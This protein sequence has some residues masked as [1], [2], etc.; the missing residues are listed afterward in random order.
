MKRQAFYSLCSTALILSLLAMLILVVSVQAEG[1]EYIRAG[2]SFGSDTLVA[3]NLQN[4][5]GSGYEFGIY[6]TNGVFFRLAQTDETKITMIKDHNIY[7]SSGR[8]YD[9]K[10]AAS[11][12]TIGAYHLQ[13]EA[14]FDSYEDTLTAAQSL[15]G[16]VAWTQNGYRVRYGSYTTAASAADAAAQV[17]NATLP[18]GRSAEVCA[19]TSSQYGITVC[20]TGTDR[21]LFELDLSAGSS[22]AVRPCT[23]NGEKTATW[24]KGF[25]Y[26]GSF[27]YSRLTGD[28]L[29]VVNLVPIEDYVACVVT[30]EMSTSWPIEA[31]K[32]G[33]CAARTFAKKETKHQDLGFDVCGGTCCQVY[34]GLY[35]T[36]DMQ[37]AIRA[38]DE[39]AG[40]CIYYEESLIQ[41][42]YYSSNG[43]AAEAAA[44]AWGQS[45]DY[46]IEKYDP[47][48]SQTNTSNTYWAYSYSRS[49]LTRLLRSYGYNCSEI[50]S[51]RVTEYTPV[52]NVQKIVFTDSSGQTYVFSGDRVR[53]FEDSQNGK[54]FSRKYTVI[55]PHS[56]GT[57]LR[58]TA[59]NADEEDTQIVSGT[60]EITLNSVTFG[61]DEVWAQEPE[62]DA[63]PS[64]QT[65]SDNPDDAYG[66]VY[67]V[68]DGQQI[69][70]VKDL[71]VITSDG[72]QHKTDE[73]DMIFRD[74]DGEDAAERNEHSNNHTE[75]T[76]KSPQSAEVTAAPTDYPQA[77]LEQIVISND[78]DNYLIVGS[79]W[80][81]NIGM[82]QYGAKAMAELG[83]SYR[84]ILEYY[85]T[86]VTV[87]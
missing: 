55:A 74:P 77:K 70:T 6:D 34:A 29:T 42:L 61:D 67:Y 2:L 20:A 85:Y 9:T 13:A 24:F 7:L 32:A 46:L 14:E 73:D 41:A 60:S 43:G 52:G 19:V 45:V 66:D 1:Q 31:L 83:Y 65:G 25:Q 10:T 3:A 54:Y 18:D 21:I 44:Y 76:D 62:Q 39:T 40:E 51:L 12:T 75:E 16:F 27:L 37:P 49:Q 57:F 58:V 87:E 17:K 80:G 59:E 69:T 35:L 36:G 28:D 84:Q 71:Y 38:A 30:R 50:S 68:Y 53:L 64:V 81:H 26:Y 22:L 56:Q 82:S 48:E 63:K 11:Y 47:F 23:V 72:I 8:Y 15:E 86:G 4:E 79:G 5:I 33:A 78:S